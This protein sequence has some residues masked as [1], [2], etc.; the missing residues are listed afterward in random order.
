MDVKK[1]VSGKIFPNI[2]NCTRAIRMSII[3]V[4]RYFFC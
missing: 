3:P 1:Y 4:L 2:L